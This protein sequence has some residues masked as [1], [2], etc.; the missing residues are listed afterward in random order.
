MAHVGDLQFDEAPLLEVAE[1]VDHA[2]AFLAG[3]GVGV[4]ARPDAPLLATRQHTSQ[5]VGAVWVKRRIDAGPLATCRTY[6]VTRIKRRALLEEAVE[7][8]VGQDRLQHERP[9]VVA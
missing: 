7:L 9:Y 8:E 6:A 5:E 4:D 3:H 2:F 1:R